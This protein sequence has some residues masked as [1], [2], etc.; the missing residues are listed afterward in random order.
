MATALGIDFGTTNS[1]VCFFDGSNYH[2]ADLEDKR[3]TIPS[4]IYVDNKYYPT[5]GESA[6]S[7]FLRDNLNRKIKLEK[8][9]LGYIEIALGD[10]AY[11]TFDHTGF[12]PAPTTYDAKISG[13][14]DKNL[15][16]FLFAST[17]RLLGQS[18]FNSVRLFEKNIKLEAVVA[19]IIRNIHER[20]SAKWSSFPSPSICIGRP[21]NYECSTGQKQE[22]CN[23]I[24]VSRM[25]RA[26]EYAGIRRYSYFLEPIAPVLSHLHDGDEESDQVVL[27]LDFGGGTLDFSLLVKKDKQVNVLGS[28][29]QPLG[30]D[31]I[32]EALI[33]D[34]VFPRIGLSKGNL[35]RLKD[36]H[37]Y[38][39]D[40]IPDIL[41][42]RTTFILNQPKYFMEIAQAIKLL[43]EEAEKLNRIRLI[44]VR[45]RPV[46]LCARA[47]PPRCGL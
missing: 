38:L 3:R 44:G 23:A 37:N 13:F 47:P 12:D 24:A 35:T 27:V 17:K 18:E 33:K 22:K 16:G 8:T 1:T 5:Y 25:G 10:N 39:E 19:S 15:P 45:A 14:T 32:T 36:Q 6:R 41:N 40:T 4:L 21:V 34:F 9:D 46:L 43:P 31:I 11:E 20:A 42:W 26:L 7:Q 29:G 28:H 2:Y 30:G